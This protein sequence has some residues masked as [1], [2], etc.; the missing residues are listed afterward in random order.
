M[1]AAS[2]ACTIGV[3]KPIEFLLGVVKGFPLFVVGRK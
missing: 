2:S 3:K 1:S